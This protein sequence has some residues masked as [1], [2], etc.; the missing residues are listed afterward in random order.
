MVT[1]SLS[2]VGARLRDAEIV[3]VACRMLKAWRNRRSARRLLDMNAREL[4]DIGLT[5]ADVQLAFGLSLRE[6]P[7]ERLSAWAVERRSARH[8]SPA[9]R[10]TTSV[11]RIKG[12]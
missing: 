11:P 8:A 4:A 12:C 2:S 1:L 3:S 6:D 9:E 10:R 7:T 5:P